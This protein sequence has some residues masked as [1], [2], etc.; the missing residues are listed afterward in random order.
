MKIKKDNER[1]LRIKEICKEAGRWGITFLLVIF[2]FEMVIFSIN[3]IVDANGAREYRWL[4][5]DLNEGDYAGFVDSYNMYIQLGNFSEEEY[6]Q[7]E[8][9][10]RFYGEYILAVEYAGAKD[11]DKYE[12]YLDETIANMIKIYEDTVYNDNIPHYEYLLEYV[13]GI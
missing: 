5:K 12:K 11:K 1:I 6:P 7:F 9:F 13:N 4:L 2:I 3:I 8:E 10:K